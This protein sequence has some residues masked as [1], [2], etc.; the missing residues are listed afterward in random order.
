SLHKGLGQAQGRR[1]SS[2]TFLVGIV[3]MLQAELFP[4][5]QEPQK[6]ACA[7]AARYQQDV[8]DSGVDQRLDWIV[9]HWLVVDREQMFVRHLGQGVEPRAK[10]PGENDAFH[11]ACRPFAGRVRS[12]SLAY[13]MK[14]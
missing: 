3:Q 10:S 9:D 11:R 5:A 12:H 14:L 2:L 4:V 7:V 6:V 8:G 13:F 1:D